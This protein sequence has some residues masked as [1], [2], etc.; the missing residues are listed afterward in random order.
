MN[1]RSS[2]SGASSASASPQHGQ[3]LAERP[4]IE[5]GRDSHRRAAIQ[6]DLDRGCREGWEAIG[7]D[8]LH[9]KEDGRYPWLGG[10]LFRRFRVLRRLLSIATIQLASPPEE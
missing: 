5:P 6:Q 8:D 3:D 4:G 1:R 2:R 7:I 10:S 9:R